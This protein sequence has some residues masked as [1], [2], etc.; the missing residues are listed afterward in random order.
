MAKLAF[1]GKLFTVRKIVDKVIATKEEVTISGFIPTME[2]IASGKERFRAED[3]DYW[4]SNIPNEGGKVGLRAINRDC[5][6]T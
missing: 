2:S 6:A 4:N 3:S 5:W 1:E